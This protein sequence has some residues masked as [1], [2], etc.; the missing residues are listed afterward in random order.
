MT[1][2]EAKL[3][4]QSYRPGGGVPAADPFF[5]VALEMAQSNKELQEWFSE[6]RNF[7]A[8]MIRALR[9]EVPPA[10]LRETIL[11]KPHAP[12][13]SERNGFNP[14]FPSATAG[15]PRALRGLARDS[16]FRARLHG[17]NRSR[18]KE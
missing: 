15:H 16:P 14:L 17:S 11:A 9:S 10:W 13:T 12:S 6:Q 18:F 1:T 3:I 8:S 4:L 5:A 2:Q 7:D